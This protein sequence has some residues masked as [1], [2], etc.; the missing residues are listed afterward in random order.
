MCVVS[1]FQATFHSHRDREEE[2]AHS[3]RAASGARV[4]PMWYRG[5]KLGHPHGKTGSPPSPDIFRLPFGRVRAV[6]AHLHQLW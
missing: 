4:L 1:P 2:R 5:L 3:T 6:D